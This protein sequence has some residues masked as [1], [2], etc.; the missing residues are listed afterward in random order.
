A[1]NYSGV[2]SI[3]FPDKNINI[4]TSPYFNVD[5]WQGFNV[6][7]IYDSDIQTYNLT[8]EGTNLSFNSNDLKSSSQ[9]DFIYKID[10]NGYYLQGVSKWLS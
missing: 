8:V 2:H 1:L 6:E 7:Y 9:Q 10:K 5:L 4:S 3:E